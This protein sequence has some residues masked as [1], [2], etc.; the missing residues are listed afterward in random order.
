MPLRNVSDHFLQ[1]AKTA[2]SPFMP[3]ALVSKVCAFLIEYTD[4]F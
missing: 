3:T 1:Q 4:S 2:Q